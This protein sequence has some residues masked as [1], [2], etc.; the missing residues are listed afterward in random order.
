M[1]GG[2]EGEEAE[3]Q[4]THDLLRLRRELRQG[5]YVLWYVVWRTRTTV[6]GV[7]EGAG[8]GP[9]V[10]TGEGPDEDEGADQDECGRGRTE[11]VNF[12]RDD[13]LACGS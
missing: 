2:E 7:G 6:G 10:G 12:Q 1:C 11:R 13:I 8:E 3:G 4:G 5:V 9:D